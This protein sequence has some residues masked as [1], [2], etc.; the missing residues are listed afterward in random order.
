MRTYRDHRFEC[1][2]ST[3]EKFVDYAAQEDYDIFTQE[4]SLNDFHIIYADKKFS[5]KNIKPRRY[6][7]FY[8]EYKN[9]QSNRLYCLFTDNFQKVKSY[10]N[11]VGLENIDLL[12][13]L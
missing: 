12:Y 8:Y 9:T 5:G 10:A 3:V 4:G 13:E 7:I 1:D 2:L 11:D 6:I